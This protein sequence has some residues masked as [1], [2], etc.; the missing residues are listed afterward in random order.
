MTKRRAIVKRV[1]ARLGEEDA[2]KLAYLTERD[3]RTVSEVLRL[4]LQRYYDQ[5][6]TAEGSPWKLLEQ[7]GF[8][9]SAEGPGDLSVNYKQYL[10]GG[11]KSKHGR[12]R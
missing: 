5:E 10:W 7:T 2:K 12:R 1:N 3:G 4:A 9:G 11:P 8:I 6:R